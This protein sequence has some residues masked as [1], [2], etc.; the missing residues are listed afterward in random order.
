[1]VVNVL[2]A[3]NVLMNFFKLIILIKMESGID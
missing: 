1:M 3:M 2:A